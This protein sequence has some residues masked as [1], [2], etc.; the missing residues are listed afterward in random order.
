VI[1]EVI[2]PLKEKRDGHEKKFEMPTK[3]PV[4]GT[5]VVGDSRGIIVKCPSSS[6]YAQHMESIIHFVSRAAFDIEHVGPALIEQLIE[7]K[8]IEDSADLFTLEKGDLMNLERMGEKSAQNV[9]DSLEQKKKVTLPRFIYALGITHIGEQTAQDL[10]DH[11]GTLDKL[12]RARLSELEDLFGI[13]EKASE[14]IYQYFQNEKN[15]KFISKL[16]KAGVKIIEEKKSRE[17]FGKS[18]VVTG[19]LEKFS[20]EVAEEEI[21]KRGGKAGSA[22]SA[23][24]SYLVVGE[25][26]GSKYEKAK[27]LGVTILDEKEFIKLLGLQ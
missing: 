8:L 20:R 26:P 1:P 24:T 15:K 3:C 18:F 6:C 22:V 12:E 14:S 5:K 9:V 27:K 4:C 25:K 11:F 10:A 13:G 2:R 19:S 7:N 16:L 17:L 23:N 21:R